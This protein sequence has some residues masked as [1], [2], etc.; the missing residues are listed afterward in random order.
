MTA[1]ARTLRLSRV[2]AAAGGAWLSVLAAAPAAAAPP[3]TD[4]RLG[5]YGEATRLMAEFS[6]LTSLVSRAH[7]FAK[8]RVLKAPDAPPVSIEFGNLFQR[9]ECGTPSEQRAPK[10]AGR[11]G[12]QGPRQ[13]FPGTILSARQGDQSGAGVDRR[14]C[15]HRASRG[16]LVSQHVDDGVEAYS[17]S[18]TLINWE[19]QSINVATRMSRELPFYS[20]PPTWR[21][22]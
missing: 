8:L 10:S 12:H 6:S 5:P 7:R 1:A 3:V 14:V 19:W 9:A 2:A 22:K 4:V 18:S 13:A 21:A 20:Q 17:L 16:S 15:Q 11:G